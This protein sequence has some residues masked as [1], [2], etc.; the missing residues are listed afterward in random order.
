VNKHYRVAF[1]SESLNLSWFRLSESDLVPAP[2]N[3]L[4]GDQ[5]ILVLPSSSGLPFQI[6]L[7]FG[8]SE[9]I[10]KVVPQ[11]V[12]DI[13]SEVSETWLFSWVAKAAA[14]GDDKPLWKISGIAF[15]PEFSPQRLCPDISWRL[16][17][18]DVLLVDSSDRTAFRLVTP[19]NEFVA[20]FPEKDLIG[21]IIRDQSI[22]LM[23]VLAA[24]GIDEVRDVSLVKSPQIVYGKL[25]AL[26]D[27][28]GFLDLSGWRQGKRSAALRWAA[29]SLVLLF[30]GLVLTGHFFLWFECYLYESAAQRTFASVSSAFSQT[31]PGVPMIDAVSQ[32]RRKIT[33]AENSL[34]EAGTLPNIRWLDMM[35]LLEVAA[36][37]GIKMLKAGGRDNGFR[38]QGA[39]PDYTSLEAYRNRIAADARVESVTMPESRKSGAEVIF[40]LEGRWK[41]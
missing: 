5:D 26:L 28:S 34:R 10:R 6:E 4:P 8:D 29:G 7:P 14:G 17:I 23:P 30:L 21:R 32:L 33:D 13:Y 15:P 24:L 11:F 16:V 19:A 36:D 12:A 39:A 2:E 1:A 31:L 27:D 35:S 41:N 25:P 20:V 37:S 9:K 22:P 38:F 3:D 18:P 40:V